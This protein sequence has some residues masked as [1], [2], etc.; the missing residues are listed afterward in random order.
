MPLHTLSCDF[1]P[2]RD[3]EV[4]RAIKTLR[5]INGKPVKEFWKDVDEEKSHKKP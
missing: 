5:T 1:K 4:L 3:A 2:E